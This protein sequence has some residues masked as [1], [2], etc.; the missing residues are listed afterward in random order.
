MYDAEHIARLEAENKRMREALLPFAKAA[1]I[2]LCGDWKDAESILNTGAA[3][4]IKFG[5]LRRAFT[6][7]AALSP[8][9][10]GGDSA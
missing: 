3:W 4:P 6:T 2:R 8:T 5:D 7:L 9:S 1:E 10:N